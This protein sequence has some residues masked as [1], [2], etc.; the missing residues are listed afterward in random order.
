MSPLLLLHGAIGSAHQL[1]KLANELKGTYDVYP[2]NFSGHGVEPVPAESFSIEAFAKQV[3]A[4]IQQLPPTTPVNIFGYSMGGYVAMYMAKHL[5]VNIGKIITLGTKF[6]WNETVA[7]KESKMLQPNVIEQKV[8]AFAK[9]LSERHGAQQWKEVLYKTSD[10]LQQMGKKNPLQPE[11]YNQIKN[12]SLIMLG[13]RD[14]MV[15]RDETFEVY[16]QL[17]NAQLAILPGTPH[18]IEQADCTM[19]AYHLKKFIG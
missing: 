9:Q 17:I 2:I 8:P 4:F 7:A 14:K 3:A 18:A 6:H 15:T 19:I 5:Q 11:D 1:E 13:D 12:P 10:M 16:E